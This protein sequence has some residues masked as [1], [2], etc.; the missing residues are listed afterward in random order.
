MESTS[1]KD[2]VSIGKVTAPH[3]LRGEVRVLPLTD[4]ERR[5]E[6]LER[7][8]VVT[9]KG[10]GVRRPLH[11]VRVG[12]R[13]H[14][15][16][17]G[18]REVTTVEQAE[19][20]RDALLQVPIDEVA[21]LP[22]GSYYVFQLVGLAVYTLAGEYVGRVADVLTEDLPNDVYVVEREHGPPALIPAVRQFVRKIDL[23]EGCIIIDPI[24]GLL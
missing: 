23:E 13:K 20:L 4:V 22:E 18:F 12:Y 17:L 16:I 24:P 8:F 2:W 1:E 11:V 5:F 9:A 21:P 7:L 10:E 19:G 15:V 6:K 3:G 14:M